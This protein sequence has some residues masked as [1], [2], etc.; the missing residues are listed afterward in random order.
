M[1][2]VTKTILVLTITLTINHSCMLY[3][4]VS[5]SAV[6]E[7]HYGHCHQDYLGVDSSTLKSIIPACC[8]IQCCRRV[9]PMDTVTRTVSR[10]WLIHPHNQSFPHSVVQYSI[11]QCCR[12][13]SLWTLSPG[14]YLG[15]WLSHPQS[16]IPSLRSFHNNSSALR[17]NMCMRSEHTAVRTYTVILVVIIYVIYVG[18]LHGQIYHVAD[19]IIKWT[20][21]LNL[22]PFVGTAWS[23]MDGGRSWVDSASEL[24]SW[25][26]WVQFPGGA[27]WRCSVFL[28][29]P[30]WK[31]SLSHF[32]Q[33]FRRSKKWF[34]DLGHF[35]MSLTILS[36]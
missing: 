21:K 16:I 26:P 32:L 15:C 25:R 4:T 7:C 27:G 14:L 18:P 3:N 6:A 29:F 5:Y 13:V 8:I 36:C 23:H 22:T 1:D 33:L 34:S 12:R 10:C 2:T 30:T 24:K 35:S 28:S 19:D 31:N 17:Q 20:E 9:L 11:I